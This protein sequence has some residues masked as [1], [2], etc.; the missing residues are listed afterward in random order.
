MRYYPFCRTALG[1]PG[2]SN[3]T[4]QDLVSNHLLRSISADLLRGDTKLFWEFWTLHYIFRSIVTM[5]SLRLIL[6][7]VKCIVHCPKEEGW[8]CHV[9]RFKWRIDDQNIHDFTSSYN[10]IYLCSHQLKK[11]QCTPKI[12]SMLQNSF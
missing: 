6:C 7:S 10:I 3:S 9:Q 1:T 2:L 4:E 8:P 11:N 5:H 12:I